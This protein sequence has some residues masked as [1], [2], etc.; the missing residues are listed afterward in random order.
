M[1]SLIAECPNVTM[2]APMNVDYEHSIEITADP[3]AVWEVMSNVE[4]WPDW[5]E[6]VRSVQ[7]L[8]RGGL[9]PGQR[10]R[11][12]QPRLPVA[13]WTVEQIEHGRSFSWR[14]DTTGLRSVGEHTVEAKDPDT[15]R[16]VLRLAHSGALAGPVRFLYGGMIRRYVKAEAEGLKRAS[17]ASWTS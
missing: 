2:G 17:E 15:S 6:S 3:E 13:I 16:V 11:I 4:R 7:L 1:A 14:S 12:R 10:A 5:N 9:W 8:D